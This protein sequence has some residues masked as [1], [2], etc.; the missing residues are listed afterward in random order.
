MIVGTTVQLGE[1][2]T[3]IGGQRSGEAYDSARADLRACARYEDS[4]AR[5]TGQTNE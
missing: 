3:A 4:D 5:H 2:G 1:P